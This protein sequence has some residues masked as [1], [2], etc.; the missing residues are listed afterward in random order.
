MYKYVSICDNS[1]LGFFVPRVRL[2]PSSLLQRTFRVSYD[3]IVQTCAID[4][5]FV[6][7]CDSGREITESL[8]VL[9]EVVGVAQRMFH[10]MVSA[11]LC[12]CN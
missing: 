6:V 12:N 10:H 4:N 3:T 1:V 2:N 9:Q 7:S 11:I 5:I 8:R